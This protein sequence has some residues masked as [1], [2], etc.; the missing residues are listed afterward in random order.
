MKCDLCDKEKI[1]DEIELYTKDKKKFVEHWCKEC[2]DKKME[3]YYDSE[4]DNYISEL[5]DNYME[6]IKI[7]RNGGF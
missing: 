6:M 3:E 2:Q 4:Y 7:N 5:Y 1:V